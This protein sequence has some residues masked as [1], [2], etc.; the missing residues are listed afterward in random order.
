MLGTDLISFILSQFFGLY[1]LILSLIL[2]AR[3]GKYRQLIQTLDPKSGTL[4]LAGLIG[5]M[6]GLFFVGLHNV[7]V[8]KP[9]ITITLFCWLVLLLG[10]AYQ[11]P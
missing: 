11:S 8:I 7:W 2:F 10:K 4:V 1:L 6:L 3:E 9:V 5:L